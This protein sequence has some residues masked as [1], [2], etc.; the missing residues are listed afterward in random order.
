[1]K[2][3]PEPP[4]AHV[5]GRSSSRSR[6]EVVA[7]IREVEAL[8]GEREVRHDRVGKRDRERRPVVERRIGDAHRG[9]GP[10]VGRP[11]RDGQLSLA[12]PRQ[13][14]PRAQELP[15]SSVASPARFEARHDEIAR[16][17]PNDARSSSTRWI[18]PGQ[19]IAAASA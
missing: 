10:R 11:R 2:R 3:S 12:T 17:K 8:V 13:F 1:M 5:V 4:I 14:R 6:L 15:S 19:H 9:H 18:E 16:E 7:G